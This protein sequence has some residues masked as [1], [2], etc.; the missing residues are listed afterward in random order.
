MGQILHGSATATA[1]VRRAI[2]HSHVWTY[3]DPA[4]LQP[5]LANSGPRVTTADVYP[6]SLCGL[7]TIV[8]AASHDGFSRASTST[9]PRHWPKPCRSRHQVRE[10]TE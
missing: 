3:M 2:Q 7:M 6:A 8:V 9:A 10:A 5:G 4:R 1:A